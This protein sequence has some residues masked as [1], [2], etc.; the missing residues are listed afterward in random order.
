MCFFLEIVNLWNKLAALALAAESGRPCR[1]HQPTC[2]LALTCAGGL[3]RRLSSPG[4][5]RPSRSTLPLQHR[6]A[7]AAL[8]AAGLALAHAC[9]LSASLVGCSTSGGASTPEC[10]AEVRPGASGRLNC[11]TG[12][13]WMRPGWRGAVRGPRGAHRGHPERCAVVRPASRLAVLH[14]LSAP[15][16]ALRSDCSAWTAPFALASAYAPARPL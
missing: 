12:D 5:R 7:L 15:A 3:W 9:A 10:A 2:M 14:L 6:L 16:T 13:C 1:T 8:L 11:A 4:P